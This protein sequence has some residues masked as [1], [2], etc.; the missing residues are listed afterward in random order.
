MVERRQVERAMKLALENSEDFVR[1]SKKLQEIGSLGHA[2]SLAILGF[3]EAHKA[4]LISSFHPLFDGLIREEYRNGLRENL[5]NHSWKQLY[6]KEFRTAFE[7]MLAENDLFADEKEILE[8]PS[9]SEMKI[10]T[11]FAFS[12]QLDKMKNDGFYTDPFKEPIWYPSATGAEVLEKAQNLLMTQIKSVKRFIEKFTSLD[13]I[14]ESVVKSAKDEVFGILSIV[15][16]FE[17]EGIPNLKIIEEK[18]SA[19]GEAG[20]LIMAII[21]SYYGSE[22]MK[23]IQNEKKK[24]DSMMKYL[25]D[26]GSNPPGAT[27]IL[28]TNLWI[29]KLD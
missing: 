16:D 26:G 9:L 5:R 13:L 15:S 29:H 24:T 18:L 23:H 4:Y 8:L 19:F 25:I 20:K 7:C 27:I 3:E 1:D 10:G 17:K 21:K 6:A 28:F 2:T 14:P 11:E 12:K 22:Q